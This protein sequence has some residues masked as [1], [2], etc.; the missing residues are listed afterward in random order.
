MS[1]GND[2]AVLPEEAERELVGELAALMVAEAAPE[3]L[4]AFDDAKDRYFRA[5][6]SVL[7]GRQPDRALGFGI[8]LAV[9]APYAL[10]VATPVV[11]FLATV[12][13]KALQE[14][15]GPALI[16]A[17]RRLLRRR[18][19]DQPAPTP[20]PPPL[21]A[22]QVKEVRRIAY[23][24]ALALGLDDD[25]ARLLADAVIGGLVAA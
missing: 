3:E 10:A 11:R 8:D 4:A 7:G 25:R 12:M 1:V 13:Q 17:V 24:R 9:L 2:R 6:E 21:T 18:N 19:A 16:A 5:P 14:E 23:E 22:A 15:V 20:P